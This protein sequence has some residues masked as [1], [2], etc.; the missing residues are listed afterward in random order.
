M[1][2][3]NVPFAIAGPASAQWF[4]TRLAR[5]CSSCDSPP[6]SRDTA[7]RKRNGS[8]LRR[9]RRATSAAERLVPAGGLAHAP[10]AE[11]IGNGNA[12]GRVIQIRTNRNLDARTHRDLLIEDEAD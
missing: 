9:S 8:G 4:P 12:E 3:R 7:A 2:A 1:K 6:G 10:A 11:V 5:S